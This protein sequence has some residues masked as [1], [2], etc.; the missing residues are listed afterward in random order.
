MDW[1]PTVRQRPEIGRSR[2]SCRMSVAV[3]ASIIARTLPIRHDRPSGDTCKSI[4]ATNVIMP[5][6]AQS[7]SG[8]RDMPHCR[9]GRH[10]RGSRCTIGRGCQYWRSSQSGGVARRNG[11]NEPLGAQGYA[12]AGGA[13]SG[14]GVRVPL[15]RCPALREARTRREAVSLSRAGDADRPQ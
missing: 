11:E 7:D 13:P 6:A 12:S 10:E 9:R 4:V 14:V 8:C 5:K 2:C 15:I 1:R 3:R